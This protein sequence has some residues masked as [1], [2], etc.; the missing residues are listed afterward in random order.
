MEI[1]KTT[2]RLNIQKPFRFLHLSDTHLTYADERDGERKVALSENRKQ[3]FTVSEELLQKASELSKE[4]QIPILHSGDMTDFVSL[5]NLERVKKFVDQNDIFMAAGNHEF[6]L[7]VGEAKEDAAYRN[8]SLAKVQSVFHNNIR[9]SARVIGEVNFVALDNSYYLW[10]REQLNFLKGEVAKGLPIILL[11]H[12]PLFDESLFE[13]MMKEK[14]PCAHQMAVPRELMKNYP[15]ARYEQQLADDI[16]LEG[17]EYIHNAPEI[18]VILSGHLHFNFEG[19]VA[20]RIEQ[21]V[22]SRKDI[23]LIEVI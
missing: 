20:D 2:L 17:I 11:V 9:M 5:A 16:T 22:T 8:Q 13:Y 4:L 12:T 10:E 1:I 7:F 15:P 21:I 18:K 3:Y 6:S 14:H 19:K 23:R